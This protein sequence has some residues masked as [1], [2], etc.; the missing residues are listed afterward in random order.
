MQKN[1]IPKRNEVPKEYTW[2]TEDIFASREDWEKALKECQ[3]YT[4][5]LKAFS[6]RLS[7]SGETLLQLF[8]LL[9]EISV[10]AGAVRQ[11]AHLNA[12]TD[13]AD[14]SLQAM[15]GKALSL[16]VALQGAESFVRPE[17]I[18]LSD[19]TLENFYAQCPGLT[20]YR[21]AIEE[22]PLLKDHILSPAE[23]QLLAAAGEISE[24]PETIGSMF[25]NADLKFPNV[26]DR[27]GNEQQLT[28]GAYIP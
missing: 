12:D 10:K 3:G 24:S 11:Y 27:D 1:K 14:S 2:A 16:L 18:A 13:T 21:R 6:G 20:L 8:Q 25:R 19:E 7:E 22:D 23:K 15:S 17:L 4:E 28:P 5:K 9:D 26:L